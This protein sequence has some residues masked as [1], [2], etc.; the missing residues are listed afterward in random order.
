MASHL[1]APCR[2]SAD[3]RRHQREQDQFVEQ[4]FDEFQT[5]HVAAV[6]PPELVAPI[7][8]LLIARTQVTDE[9]LRAALDRLHEHCADLWERQ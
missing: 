9:P 4:R 6:V 5:E 3:L 2:V 7:Q 8:A 1:E